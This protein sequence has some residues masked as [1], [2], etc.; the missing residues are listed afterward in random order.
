MLCA[1]VRWRIEFVGDG[2]SNHE[3]SKQEVKQHFMHYEDIILCFKEYNLCHERITHSMVD[4]FED[5][6]EEILVSY[7][8]RR[9]INNF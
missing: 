8:L 5:V 9:T 2:L 3:T 1:T 6:G 4:N 7:W